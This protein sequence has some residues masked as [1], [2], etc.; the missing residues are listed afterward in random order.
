MKD[1]KFGERDNY[2][3]GN[4]A[5]NAILATMKHEEFI[6]SAENDI[7]KRPEGKTMLD[8]IAANPTAWAGWTAWGGG[9]AWSE[10][11]YFLFEPRSFVATIQDR[12]MLRFLSAYATKGTWPCTTYASGSSGPCATAAWPYDIQFP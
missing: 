4:R 5:L 2:A 10:N 3:C 1:I 12:P 8:Y 11:Y 9:P 7:E 6:E